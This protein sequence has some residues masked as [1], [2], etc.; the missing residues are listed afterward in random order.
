[1]ITR[2]HPASAKGTFLCLLTVVAT[3]AFVA[4]PAVAEPA[5]PGSPQQEGSILTGAVYDG[6][7]L[8]LIGALIAVA[9]PGGEQPT[10]LTASD[11]RGHFAV[12]L[13]PGIYTLVAR[14]FG[15]VA[16]IVPGVQV[17]RAE[18]V[19]LQLR[20]ERQVVS[21]LSDNAPLDIGYAF[22]P[23]V[24]DVLRGTESTI[25]TGGVTE[26]NTA[27]VDTLGEGSVWA[28][29]G[30]ELS[31]WTVAPTGNAVEDSRSATEFSMGSIGSG[32]Q[33]WLLRGQLGAGGVVR[34][35]SDLS[36][37]TSDA[38]ALRVGIGFA[39]R[40]LAVPEGEHAA[41]NMWVG[42]L[43]AEDFWRLGDAAQ[44]GFGVRFEHYNYLEETGLIS[45]R[46][47]IAF[48]PVKSVTLTTG[49]SYDAEAPGLAE[50]RFQVDPL[51][52]RYV[53]VI[54]IDTIDPERTLRYELG[55]H[56]ATV[57]TEW[58]ARAYHDQITDELVGVY[59]ANQQGSS[60][61]VVANLG[62]SVMQGFEVDVRRSFM[63]SVSGLFSYAYGRREGA[64]L[65]ADLVAE[66]GLLAPDF[67]TESAAVDSVHEVAA[68]VE[69]VVGGYE[70]RLNATYHWQ[71]GIP[72]VRAGNLES[73]YER[74]DFR[75]RQP[76]PFTALSS[77]WSALLQVQNV[78][79]RSYDGVFDFRLGDAPVLN[80]LFSGGLAIRF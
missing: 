47:Q 4:Q 35:R 30:G 68:G 52:V 42:S 13:T 55:V 19:R 34:A 17:P 74:L 36:R 1:M 64:A 54:G 21:L 49:I 37:V 16:A 62:D 32:A 59:L 39:G 10:A 23:R 28:N 65:P 2:S 9:I 26:T 8:P 20:S 3:S 56:T 43:I 45:P 63:D 67:E 12:P 57:N 15:H 41:R 58:R 50:L 53:D 66:R 29:V 61:Y 33:S 78:L 51:A 6:S 14:S 80:R 69:T 40:D 44:V 5:P 31:L 18:P 70:T 77:D 79:G 48:V 25:D 60:D 75:V 76:L 71:A 7:G 24:R 27:W 73:V 22:R 38:H 72:V 11:A 46:M